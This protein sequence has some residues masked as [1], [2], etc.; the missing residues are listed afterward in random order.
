MN[1][2]SKNGQNLYGDCSKSLYENLKMAKAQ[3]IKLDNLALN[4]ESLR[5]LDLAFLS[6]EESD[7]LHCD[8]SG[9]NFN[10]TSFKNSCLNHCNFSYCDLS[11]VDF[12][13]ADLKY[14]VF[15]GANLSNA[16]FDNAKL[17][18]V[19]PNGIEIKGVFIDELPAIWNKDRFFL[20]CKE[21]KANKLHK[22]LPLLKERLGDKALACYEYLE[23]IKEF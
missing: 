10:S 5:G 17:N 14:C 19:V 4:N 2:I 1:L 23:K 21:F 11:G 3:G 12:S 22:S 6:F 8:F 7:F 16:I 18:F 15:V 20:G 13:G 9:G